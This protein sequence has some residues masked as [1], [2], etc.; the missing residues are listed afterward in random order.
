MVK[1]EEEIDDDDCCE[2]DPE[3]FAKKVQFRVFD[4]VILVAAKGPIKVEMN[5]PEGFPTSLDA[6]D[7]GNDLHL[8]HEHAAGDHMD[9]PF[10]VDEDDKLDNGEGKHRAD[11]LQVDEDGRCPEKVISDKVPVKCEPED[12]DAAGEDDAYDLLPDINGFSHELFPDERRVFDEEDD[13]DVVVVRRD[14][15]EPFSILFFHIMFC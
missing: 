8:H 7:S 2:I 9:I 12:H 13:D 4:D 14:A 6:S 15:P 1:I 5:P 11:V 10:E 3:E